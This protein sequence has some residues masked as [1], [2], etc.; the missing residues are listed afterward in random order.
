[1]PIAIFLFSNLAIAKSLLSQFPP[2]EENFIHLKRHPCSNGLS[3]DQIRTI[4][5]ATELVHV[6]PEAY[7]HRANQTVSAIHLVVQGGLKAT[8]QDSHGAQ[9][10]MR[11]L[12]R[13][14]Q[15]GVLAGARIEP[16]PLNLIASEPSTLLRLDYQKMLEFA[17]KFPPFQLSLF[18]LVGDEVRKQLSID[19]ILERPPVVTVVHHTPHSRPLTPSLIRRLQQLGEQPCVAT[20]DP[21]WQ[22]LKDTPTRVL[23]ENGRLISREQ[24]AQQ[25]KEWSNFGRVFI[26]CSTALELEELERAINFGDRI[27]WCVRPQDWDAASGKIRALNAKVPAWREKT[28]LI[29][30]LDEDQPIAP[31]APE[32]PDLVDRDLKI[33][34]CSPGEN[35]NRLLSHGIERLVHR[36]RGIQIGVA[37]GGGAARGMAHLGVLKLL[38]E[39]GI[40]VDM[41]A[42]TSAGAMTGAM[43][44]A[45]FDADYLAESFANDLR[46]SWIFRQMR[47]GGYWYLLYKYRR[48]KFDP[49]L[50][51]YMKD[52]RLEQTQVP[53]H[54]ITVDL[55][56]GEPKVRCTGDIVEGILES[57]NLPGLSSPIVHSGQALVDGGLVNNVP[58]DVLV[59]RGCNFVIAVSVTAK[60][61]QEF[62]NIRPTSAGHRNKSPST[63]QTIMRGYLV[64]STNMNSVGVHPADV[65]VEPDATEFDLSE[66]TRAPELAL[67]GEKAA[68]EA[69]PKIKQLLAQLDRQLFEP[70]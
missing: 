12:R 51:K 49:M 27:L 70:G 66:F 53:M 60:L 35:Q 36:L 5:E 25:L 23:I 63:L 61:E 16:I 33:S 24:G 21:A 47:G 52:R 67:E 14:S 55:V 58:A 37:L 50:R 6:E 9:T 28:E 29:W 11:S 65:V 54:T 34:F 62:A 7:V 19:R 32:L 20:D 43:Y 45:G 46:P 13:G 69:I 41:I 8:I 44:A 30:M 2:H 38:E 26:D 18:R 48:K 42:G 64:Q 15:F 57:I 39:N 4:A 22:P 3:D 56:S 10:E 31:Y 40:V 59:E 68:F 17:A 1:V